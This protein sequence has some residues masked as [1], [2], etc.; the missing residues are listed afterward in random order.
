MKK[1]LELSVHSNIFNQNDANGRRT[2]KFHYIYEITK[3]ADINDWVYKVTIEPFS[4]NH[5]KSFNN[6]YETYLNEYPSAEQI[7][8]MLLRFHFDF[9]ITES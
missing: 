5:T 3:S 4:S 1:T 7:E 9:Y 8:N 2:D 6:I